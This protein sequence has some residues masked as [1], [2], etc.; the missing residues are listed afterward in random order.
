MYSY[1]LLFHETKYFP[2]SLGDITVNV[3]QWE[4]TGQR[5]Y[6]EQGSADGSCIVTNH[7]QRARKLILEGYFV[8][9]TDPDSLILLLDS[10]ISSG[11]HISI[12]LRKMLFTD[13]RI[14][15]YTVLEK[16]EEPYIKLRVEI[17]APTP[18]EEAEAV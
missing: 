12:T 1:D 9:E 3:S 15:K 4:L 13:T 17:S 11:A 2:V 10:Y 14:T 5:M 6:S 18:P 16:G 8:T 7:F